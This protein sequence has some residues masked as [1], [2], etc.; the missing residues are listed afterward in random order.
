MYLN[1]TWVLK[2]IIS[3]MIKKKNKIKYA[4]DVCCIVIY[5]V[6]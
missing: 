3:N 6:K 1:R 5:L 2:K 4:A